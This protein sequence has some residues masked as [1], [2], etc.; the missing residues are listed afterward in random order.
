M[1]SAKSDII[2]VD[3]KHPSEHLHSCCGAGLSRRELFATSAG[4]SAAAMPVKAW[5]RPAGAERQPPIHLPL[6][7]QPVLVY[8]IYKRRDQTSWRP[9]G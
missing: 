7:V 6:R 2:E 8:R 5:S 9:W 3:M 1:G 4:I